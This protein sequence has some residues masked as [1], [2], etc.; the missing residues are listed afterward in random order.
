MFVVIDSLIIKLVAEMNVYAKL[1]I[2]SATSYCCS[3]RMLY[4]FLINRNLFTRNQFRV[5]QSLS[6]TVWIN[7]T[8][9][10]D[11]NQFFYSL[12]LELTQLNKNSLTYIRFIIFIFYF[13]RL[14]FFI[15]TS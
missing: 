7:V 8:N 3:A 9:W 1:L 15:F 2:T 6:R 11:R 10:F 4:F 12:D 5:N 14:S 13:I